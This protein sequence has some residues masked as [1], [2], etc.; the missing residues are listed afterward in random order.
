MRH[1][2]N[3]NV[4]H[5][6]ILTLPSFTFG[7]YDFLICEFADWIIQSMDVTRIELVPSD[8]KSDVLPLYY[9]PVVYYFLQM[10]KV[11]YGM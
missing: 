6:G 4:I 5:D 11:T 9:T 7:E 2:Q 8:C 10:Q 3:F 1:Q